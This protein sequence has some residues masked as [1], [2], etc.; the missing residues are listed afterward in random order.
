MAPDAIELPA[1]LGG[2]P[3]RPEGPPAW[4]MPDEDVLRALQAV[5]QDGSWGRYQGGHVTRLEE[6]LASYHSTDHAVACG[7]GTFAVEL[8]LRALKVGPGDEVLVAAYD[9][10][11]N[12]LSVHA[13]G[14]TPVL[15][16]VAPGN[17]NLDPT[18][19]QAAIG[20]ATRAVIA[21]HL[22]GGVVP[23]A[24]VM[25]VAG[26]HGLGVIE[27][28]AQMPGAMIQGRKAGTWGDVGVLSFGGSKLLTAGRGGALVTRSAAIYQRARVALHRGNVV[29]P[30]SELQA[31]V[32]LPQLEQLDRRNATRTQAV[33][34]LVEGLQGIPGLQPFVNDIADTTPGYYKLG[35]QFDATRFGLP[36]DRFLAAVRA[37]GIAFDDGFRALHISRSPSRFRAVGALPEAE[38]AH[39]GTVVLHHPV[40]LGT[41]DDVQQ[42]VQ[43]VGKVYA[44]AAVIS[45]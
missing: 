27:D 9:Y 23:M 6:R 10:G 20:P 41:A 1:L 17:W 40:L 14:A 15:I 31:A 4:P 8:A 29:C 35:F 33:R 2:R 12:F 30:L 45:H 28:A 3:V 44:N 37:E 22:H 39:H 24:E 19:L 25:A 11:G 7:S 16:D 43:A 13:V 42:V 36:R 38:R 32:L 21:S 34:L 26:R 18:Q 5:Y